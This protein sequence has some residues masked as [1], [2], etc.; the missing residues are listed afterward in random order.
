MHLHRAQER[1][2]LKLEPAKATL[3]GVV[4]DHIERPSEN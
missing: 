2:G 3:D 4:I 1:L